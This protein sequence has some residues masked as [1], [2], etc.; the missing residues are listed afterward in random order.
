MMRWILPI[1]AASI[2]RWRPP[3]NVANSGDPSGSRRL[4]FGLP[5]SEASIT[6]YGLEIS[7]LMTFLA[8]EIRVRA[9]RRSADIGIRTCR[10]MCS[11][12]RGLKMVVC[13]TPSQPAGACLV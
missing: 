9:C 1:R 7:R 2:R 4:F 5:A 13:F 3:L 10:F 6:R 11:C 8:A 12:G